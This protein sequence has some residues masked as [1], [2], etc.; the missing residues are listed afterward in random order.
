MSSNSKDN[1]PEQR[2]TYAPLCST[3]FILKIVCDIRRMSKRFLSNC[4]QAKHLTATEQNH[5][6]WNFC[7]RHRSYRGRTD[8]L[9]RL[10]CMN[11]SGHFFL[12]RNT[13]IKFHFIGDLCSAVWKCIFFTSIGILDSGFANSIFEYIQ[14][15]TLESPP[16]FIQKLVSASYAILK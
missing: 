3:G 1:L 16:V 14:I 4:F 12:S 7:H 5:S 11:S 6:W 9:G 13:R 2:G 10:L 15:T 8:N